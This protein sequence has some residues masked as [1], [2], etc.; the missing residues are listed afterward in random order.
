MTD[1]SEATSEN[2]MDPSSA[3]NR[4]VG[5]LL[6]DLFPE[7]AHALEEQLRQDPQLAREFYALRETLNL[8][9]YGLPGVI[10]AAGL[11]D[12][13]LAEAGLADAP[14]S[15]SAPCPALSERDSKVW[16]QWLAGVMGVA[17][18]LLG[19]D[20]WRLRQSLPLTQ[21]EAAQELVNLL[22]QP[23][24]RLVNLQGEFGVV[25]LLL[26]GEEG[27]EVVLAARDLPQLASGESYHLWLKLDNGEILHGGDFQVDAY[28]S[29]V[30]A[31]R[32]F[33][34]PPA[35]TQVRELWIT[36]QAST[37][38]QAPQGKPLLLGSV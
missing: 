17:L 37:S 1:W 10:P 28:G 18:M 23:G 20:N 35:G 5:Y 24:S 29:A 26:P 8:L 31:M 7:E 30:V 6:G 13:V 32:L 25:N 2:E 21:L 27:Q 19:L 9:P 14:L 4:L 38:R 33:R 16:W 36:A 22:Q 15:F 34:T 3:D 11:R 12:Q